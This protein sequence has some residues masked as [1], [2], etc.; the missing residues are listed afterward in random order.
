MRKHT[1]A[2]LIGGESRRMGTPKQDVELPSGQTMLDCTVAF[3]QTLSNSVVIVGGEVAGIRCIQDRR[4]GHGPVAGIEVLLESG[5]DD[6]YLVVGCDMPQLSLE[7][8]EPLLQ[9]D[10]A[11]VY[12]HHEAII[13]LPL[14]VLSSA[15]YACTEYLDSGKRSIRG[16][17]ETIPHSEISVC[18]TTAALLQSVNTPDDLNKL[19]VE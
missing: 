10:E 9:Q 19:A 4:E 15:L 5:I 18:D 3:A 17:V 8:I 7:V 13:G 12:T 1:V 11:A 14:V 6:R 16:F 2:I